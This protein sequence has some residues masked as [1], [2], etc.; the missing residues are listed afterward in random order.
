MKKVETYGAPILNLIIIPLF[1]KPKCVQTPMSIICI[2]DF[3]GIDFLMNIFIAV[4]M[5]GKKKHF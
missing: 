2:L 3:Y 5:T 1:K 4:T